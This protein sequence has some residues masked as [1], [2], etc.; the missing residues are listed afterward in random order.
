MRPSFDFS[1]ALKASLIGHVLLAVL[2]LFKGVLFSGSIRTYFP[3]LRV[4]LV[5]LPDTLKKDLQSPKQLALK[6]EIE[7]ILKAKPVPPIAKE[8]AQ[9]DGMKLKSTTQSKHSVEKQNRNAL[10][11]LKALAKIQNVTP[12]VLLKGNQIS[13]GTSLSGDSKEASESHYYDLL[14]D[15]LQENWALPSWVARQNWQAQVQIYIDFH[16]KLRTLRFLKVSGNP[17]FDEAVKRTI[18]ESQPFPF[19]P[20]DLKISLLT[21]GVLIGFPL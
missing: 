10:Q 21:D 6:K 12:P 8:M 1:R 16:G 7:K 19:P 3:T 13:P 17:Q 2:I 11:R 14:R 9:D 4:D 18:Q 20:Q 15:R 5:G